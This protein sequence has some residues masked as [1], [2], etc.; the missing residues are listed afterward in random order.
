MVF[1]QLLAVCR[2]LDLYV[3]F[4]KHLDFFMLSIQSPYLTVADK[5]WTLK[6]EIKRNKTVKSVSIWL[7]IQ[8][9]MLPNI[10]R[11][12]SDVG[13]PKQINFNGERQNYIFVK[14]GKKKK[15]TFFFLHTSWNIAIPSNIWKYLWCCFQ[16]SL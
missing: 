12:L 6:V 9:M 7:T 10:A 14:C 13:S 2:S 16:V 5:A 1:I 8:N 15:K 3:Y 4:V 11:T